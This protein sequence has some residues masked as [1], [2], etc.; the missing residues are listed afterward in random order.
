[1][2]SLLLFVI[3]CTAGFSLEEAQPL[4]SFPFSYDLRFVDLDI[5]CR[6]I[7]QQTLFSLATVNVL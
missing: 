4:L 7:T 3:N 6:L 2:F 5:E 1:L